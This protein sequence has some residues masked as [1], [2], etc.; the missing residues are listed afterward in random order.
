LKE[1]FTSEDWAHLWA[2]GTTYNLLKVAVDAKQVDKKLVLEI[3]T[4]LATVQ[5]A[6]VVNGFRI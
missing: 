5:A 2:V 4:G 3:G 1:R 6:K